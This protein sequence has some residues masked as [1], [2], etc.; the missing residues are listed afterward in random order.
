MICSS[1]NNNLYYITVHS[2]S[3]RYIY[4]TERP[5]TMDTAIRIYFI[6]AGAALLLPYTLGSPG[7]RTPFWG[8]SDRG[9]PT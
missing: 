4:N 2:C 5:V 8:M 9:Y 7:S 6:P 1:N 3:C